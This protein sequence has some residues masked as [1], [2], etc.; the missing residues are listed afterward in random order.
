MGRQHELG[1]RI[2]A[3]QDVDGILEAMQS[4]AMVEVSR[5]TAFIE[6]QRA[7]LHHMETV[8]DDFLSDRP[9]PERSVTA[10]LMIA[11]GA[12]RGFC[13]DFNQRI[14]DTLRQQLDQSTLPTQ[15]VLVGTGLAEQWQGTAPTVLAGPSVAEEV[16]QVLQR[17][18]DAVTDMLGDSR[19]APATGLLLVTH[20]SSGVVIRRLL[21]LQRE[22]VP[23]HPFALRLNLPAAHFGARLTEQYLYAL[24]HAALYDSLLAENRRRVDHME[25]A[26]HRLDERL[27]ELGKRLS[28][29]RQ[30]EITEEIEILMLSLEAESGDVPVSGSGR[31]SAEPLNESSIT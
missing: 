26:L 12:E 27:D 13:G 24:L 15:I 31:G 5:I 28:R 29:L 9:L 8:L 3:L 21:P 25:G 18:T 11:F 20:D 17:M 16:P 4:L 6:A 10:D 30:E 1:R 19:D 22:P 23:R 14:A 2:G 7:V